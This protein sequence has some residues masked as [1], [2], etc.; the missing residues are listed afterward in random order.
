[1]IHF[2]KGGM[3]IFT[4]CKI[5]NEI[6][7]EGNFKT[8]LIDP[9]KKMLVISMA[10]R[11]LRSTLT[12][13]PLKSQSR[14]PAYYFMAILRPACLTVGFFWTVRVRIP[15]LNFA[16]MSSSFASVGNEITR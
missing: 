8:W 16:S 1:M 9:Q 15:F 7:R 2:E 4:V 11:V 13:I 5:G 10:S 12:A 6:V 14:K 3:A